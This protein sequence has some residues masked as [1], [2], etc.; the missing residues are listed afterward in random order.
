MDRSDS[1]SDGQLVQLELI[2]AA[3]LIL[4][5]MVWDI[6]RR[7]GVWASL[8]TISLLDLALGL[9]AAIPPLLT[10]LLLELELDD[11]VPGLRGLR[12][13]IHR[14]LMPLIGRIRWPEAL[15]LSALAGMSEEIFFRGVLQR[16]VGIVLASVIFGLCHA[17]SL[18][19]VVWAIVV[20]CYLGW[21]AQWEGHFWV[22]IIAH[23]V[24]DL[25]GLWYIS[26]VM[27][28]RLA[29]GRPAPPADPA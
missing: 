24:V 7:L 4:V 29:G 17:L 14:V 16:E 6:S 25:V 22:P 15:L 1:T 27:G 9:V 23:T 11:Y 12:H 19:Y 8:T 5:A 21:L 20:G 3:G 28:P 18:A 2:V 26:R 13:N 10:V